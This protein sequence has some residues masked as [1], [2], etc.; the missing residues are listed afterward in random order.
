MSTTLATRKQATAIRQKMQEIRTELPYDVDDAR[1]RV[2][3]LSDWK[4]HMSRNSTP[5]LAA[6]IVAGFMIVPRKR[7]PETVVVHRESTATPPAP[8]KR[9]LLGGIAGAAATMLLRQAASMAAT[10]LASQLG[11]KPI[12]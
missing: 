3:Q 10:Q 6:A 1:E 12:N 7:S 8:A 11:N 4:Y 2:K 5:I 9:G